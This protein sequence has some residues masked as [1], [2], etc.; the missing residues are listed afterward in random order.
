MIGMIQMSTPRQRT[1][2]ELIGQ[3]LSVE[4]LATIQSPLSVSSPLMTSL[5]S[6]ILRRNVGT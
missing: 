1:F 6:G 3:K 5:Q 4:M 2:C